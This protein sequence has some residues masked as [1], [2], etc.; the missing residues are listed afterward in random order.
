MQRLHDLD[1]ALK[2]ARGLARLEALAQ[3]LVLGDELGRDAGVLGLRLR[4]HVVPL[5]DGAIGVW[6]VG[7][8]HDLDVLR[9]VRESLHRLLVHGCRQPRARDREGQLIR[10]IC[11]V[12]AHDLWEALLEQRL[13]RGAELASQRSHHTV[14]VPV[15]LGLL[16]RVGER[17]VCVVAKVPVV[18]RLHEDRVPQLVD[19]CV[20]VTPLAGEAIQQHIP[21]AR[22][23]TLMHDWHRGASLLKKRMLLGQQLAMGQM[24]RDVRVAAQQYAIRPHPLESG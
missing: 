14:V 10:L 20:V 18:A 9:R 3:V 7:T 8:V 21:H 6:W 23:L 16:R 4:E 2:L 17:G 13:G 19:L 11:G 22:R 5:P 12:K 15:L 24:P 1:A